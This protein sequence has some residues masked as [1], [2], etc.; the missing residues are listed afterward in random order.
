M[1]TFAEDR[2][3]ETF[4]GAKKSRHRDAGFASA[5]RIAPE[6]TFYV[7]GE[8]IAANDATG[9]L[10]WLNVADAIF[11]RRIG[12]IDDQV[13]AGLEKGQQCG[14]FFG[15]GL[16]FVQANANVAPSEALLV[17]GRLAGG[18]QPHKNDHFL[19]KA[20]PGTLGGFTIQVAERGG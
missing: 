5:E 12:V 11:G 10:S 14:S 6:A 2:W 8:E 16:E 19:W 17:E 1:E 20:G 9:R 7:R 13:E 15:S 18:L 3:L 4:A